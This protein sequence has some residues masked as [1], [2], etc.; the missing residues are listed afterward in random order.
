MS[1]NIV[2][3]IIIKNHDASGHFEERIEAIK[4]IMAQISY[5]DQISIR[6]YRAQEDQNIV[7][8]KWSFADAELRKKF[9]ESDGIALGP[10][11]Q[12]S[13]GGDFGDLSINSDNL[14]EE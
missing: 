13:H 7:V 11:S 2:K 5:A 1:E 4:L 14:W 9:I 12:G 6:I 10:W 3:N 8:E